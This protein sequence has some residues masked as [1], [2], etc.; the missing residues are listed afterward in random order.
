MLALLKTPLAEGGTHFPTL[1]LAGALIAAVAGIISRRP[2]AVF[3]AQFF[4]ED[5]TV[6]FADAYNHGWWRVLFEPYQGYISILPR[7]AGSVALLFPVVYAP[8]VENL[9]AIAIQALPV[10]ILLSSRS[11]RFG[12]L[13]YRASLAV[14]YLI[15][16]NTRE[17]MGIVTTSQW[18]LGLCA[19]LLFLAF[20]PTSAWTRLWQAAFLLLCSLSGPFCLFLFPISVVLLRGWRGKDRWYRIMTAIFLLGFAVQLGM[21]LLHQSSR[22]QNIRLGA[23]PEMFLRILG[24]QIYLGTLLGSN[25][26]AVLLSFRTLA[27]IA[28][29]GS[30]LIIVCALNSSTEMRALLVFAAMAFAASLS[31]PVAFPASGETAWEVLAGRAPA[32]HY[33]FLPSLAFAW[34]LA[35]CLFCRKQALQVVAG[36]LFIVMLLGVVRDYRYPPFPDLGFAQYVQALPKAPQEGLTIPENPA[37]W[38]LHLAK[39]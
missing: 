32:N 27:L 38:R 3:H 12:P 28:L 2:D 17:M 36:F 11:Q 10:L 34:S 33:W 29:A 20:A 5:G 31:H 6:W 26:L 22:H 30:T 7:L 4:A 16:P 37:G 15:L 35:W 39:R 24:G 23:S 1:W 25:V 21:F 18:I 9:I 8:L 19:L 14:I 13:R